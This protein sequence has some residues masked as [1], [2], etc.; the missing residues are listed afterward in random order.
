MLQEVIFRSRGV[1]LVPQLYM[2]ELAGRAHRRGD[3]LFLPAGGKAGF[4]TYAN[5]FFASYWE[6][7]TRLRTISLSGKLLGE[8]IVHLFRSTPDGKTLKVGEYPVSGVFHVH[9]DLFSYLPGDEATGRFFFDFEAVTD[10]SV[11]QIA[12]CAFSPPAKLAKFSL[13]IC[14]YRK[15]KYI[16]N[17]ALG[18]E[19]YVKQGNGALSEIIIVNNSGDD[20]DL[21][22]LLALAARAPVF[23]L[24]SQGNIGGAGGFARSLHESLKSDE[25]THHIFMD[26]DVF[27]DTCMLDR[28]RAFVSYCQDP[29]VVGGQ[30]MNM[31]APN[32][33]FEGGAKLDYWG[34]LNRVGEDIDGS[35]GSEVAFFDQVQQ[36]DYNAWWFACV[37]KAEAREIGL[38]LNIF[39]RGDDFEYGMRLGRA[40]V[41]TVSLP[42]LFIWHEPFENKSSAWLEYYNW[43]NRLMVA[44]IYNDPE[45]MDIPP[46]DMLRDIFADFLKRDQQQAV[47]AMARGILDFLKPPETLLSAHAGEIHA[48]L[49][50]SLAAVAQGLDAIAAQLTDDLTAMG[51]PLEGN[52][53]L[54]LRQSFRLGRDRRDV[55]TVPWINHPIVGVLEAVLAW[56]AASG[57]G[58]VSEWQARAHDFASP[59]NWCAIY[60]WE[61]APPLESN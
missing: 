55:G 56:Y 11:E 27:L 28:M 42:G 54:Q 1:T 24:V 48:A 37:P 57:R 39:I 50:Q 5:S 19:E 21:P 35:V 16:T 44:A 12:F 6:H 31:A 61:D 51:K 8:G 25:S 58:A 41:P 47:Y 36:V 60:G 32:M 40:G 26:D 7:F 38:P 17:L 29:H 23:S 22:E 53:Q 4:N 15:E 9:F 45:R 2:T 49:Q 46:A 52:P 59:R 30:M 10:V 13:G 3:R 43:R 14:T 33:V 18:L 34:F 20:G